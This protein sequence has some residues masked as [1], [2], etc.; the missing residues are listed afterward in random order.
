MLIHD[1]DD[2]MHDDDDDHDNDGHINVDHD[3]DGDDTVVLKDIE[4]AVCL[5]S[6]QENLSD[7]HDLSQPAPYTFKILLVVLVVVVVL[8]LLVP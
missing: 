6:V 8:K 7:G 1:D 4:R 2:F 5:L 3:I